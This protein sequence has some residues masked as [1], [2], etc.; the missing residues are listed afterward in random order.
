MLNKQLLFWVCLIAVIVLCIGT[1]IFVLY[2]EK[3]SYLS[4]NKL[5]E[6]KRGR[7]TLADAFDIAQRINEINRVGEGKYDSDDRRLYLDS[8]R[9]TR[10]VDQNYV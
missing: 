10:A 3:Y 5:S 1:L 8:G 4:L 7:H 2:R 6:Q 9:R